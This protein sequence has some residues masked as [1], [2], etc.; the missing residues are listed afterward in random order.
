MDE[1]MGTDPVQV[2]LRD[3]R[4]DDVPGSGPRLR[5]EIRQLRI[6]QVA[7]DQDGKHEIRGRAPIDR[8]TTPSDF[9]ILR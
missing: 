3:H 4:R 2:R 9:E 1:R 6:R 8:E 7:L 5:T